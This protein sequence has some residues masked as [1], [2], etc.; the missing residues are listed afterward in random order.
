MSCASRRTRRW[1]SASIA[2]CARPGSPPREMTA[3]LWLIESIWHSS[4]TAEPRGCRHRTRRADTRPHPRHAPRYCCAAAQPAQCRGRQKRRLCALARDRQ[5]GLGSRTETTPATR[6][7]PCPRG[8]PYSYR[9]SSRRSP[10][11]AIDA[12]QNVNRG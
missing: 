4:L 2:S 6:F 10:S 11:G 9:H 3:Q 7:R 5:T 1:L 8:R 12:R